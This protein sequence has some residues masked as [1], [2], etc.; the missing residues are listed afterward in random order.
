[1][2]RASCFR[3]WW[4][5]VPVCG[6]RLAAS[7]FRVSWV[8][9][10]NGFVPEL[11]QRQR[12]IVVWSVRLY[13]FPS[14]STTLAG[15]SIRRGPLSVGVILTVVMGSSWSATWVA[16]DGPL[17]AGRPSWRSEDLHPVLGA[18]GEE[19]RHVGWGVE[20]RWGNALGG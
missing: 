11:P 2:V 3:M 20:R 16:A 12:K 8:P 5:S 18:D 13:S 19:L 14:A 6:A 7:N 10:Q 15:P 9:S 4:R 1:M 17:P